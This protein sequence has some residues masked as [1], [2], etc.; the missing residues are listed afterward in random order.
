M[1]GKDGQKKA[2]REA[3]LKGLVKMWMIKVFVL[4][5]V[6]AVSVKIYQN[7]GD[8]VGRVFLSGVACGWL[9]NGGFTLGWL[10]RR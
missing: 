8:E 3:G 1:A 9:A 7:A 2:P 4:V 5:V 10:R 6:A